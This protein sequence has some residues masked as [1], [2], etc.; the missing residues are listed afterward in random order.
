MTLI[1]LQTE[2]YTAAHFRILS[3]AYCYIYYAV[4]NFGKFSDTV[5]QFICAYSLTYQYGSQMKPY[6]IPKSNEIFKI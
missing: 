3:S 4:H 1:C 5:T 2:N 6:Y